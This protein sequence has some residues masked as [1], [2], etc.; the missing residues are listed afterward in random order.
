MSLLYVFYTELNKAPKLVE[1]MYIMI[2]MN[3]LIKSY[4]FYVL[5]AL[6]ISLTIKASVGVSSF[7]SMN[8]ALSNASGIKIGTI[9][10]FINIM[11]LMVYM[12]MTKGQLKKKYAVQFISLVLFGSVIN[13]FTYDILGDFVVS[14]YFMRLITVALGTFI[15]GLSIGM[16]IS[17]NTITFPIESVC[18][19]LEKVS[20]YSFTS[21]RYFIDVLSILI[22]LAVSLSYALPLYVREGTLIS[23]VIFTFTMG[24]VK[25]R[26]TKRIK[27][28]L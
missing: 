12:H 4:A 19:E 20:R 27:K 8:L 22:S 21:L 5:S 25:N 7:N 16:I 13:L 18:V 23:L 9:T 10:M 17:Y 24:T 26:Y 28:A 1:R 6:G 11:F 14:N 3:K 15:G 2:Q